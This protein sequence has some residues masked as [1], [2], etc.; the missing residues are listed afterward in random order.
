MKEWGT[1]INVPTFYLTA[2]WPEIHVGDSL[3][4]ELVVRS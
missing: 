2:G 1:S 3:S 4:K